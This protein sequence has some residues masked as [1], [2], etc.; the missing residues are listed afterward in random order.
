MQIAIMSEDSRMNM[1][2]KKIY[3]KPAGSDI[4][5]VYDHINELVKVYGKQDEI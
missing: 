3:Y 2:I 5:E 4:S 1:R